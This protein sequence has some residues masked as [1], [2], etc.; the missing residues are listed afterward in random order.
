[1]PIN[2]ELRLRSQIAVHTISDDEVNKDLNTE[3]KYLGYDKFPNRLQCLT[4]GFLESLAAVY[5]F[6]TEHL[7]FKYLSIAERVFILI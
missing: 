6:K 7:C 4:R 2:K 1:M 5:S 3:R